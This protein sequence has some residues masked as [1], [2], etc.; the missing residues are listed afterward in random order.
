MAFTDPEKIR[1]A[2]AE[3]ARLLRE[4]R[5]NRLGLLRHEDAPEDWASAVRVRVEVTYQ[6]EGEPERAGYY[7]VYVPLREVSDDLADH[8]ATLAEGVV[9]AQSA[10]ARD[11]RE[12]R[13]N[14]VYFSVDDTF[15]A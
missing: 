12:G 7:V 1:E 10:L 5:E 13:G 14:V 3:E 8:P 9:D 2:R 15:P 6:R 11:Y 4:A